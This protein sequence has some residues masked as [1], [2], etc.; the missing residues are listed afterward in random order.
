MNEPY[1]PSA[2]PMFNRR[3]AL[4]RRPNVIEALAINQSFET[5]AFRKSVNQTFAMLEG[6]SRQIAG[7]AGIQ[8]TVAPIGHKIKPPAS[9]ERSKAR[10][11]W[12]GQARP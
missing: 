9:H 2:R 11:G 8:D 7:D 10:R 5:M 3:L 1:L 4:N 6:A 12:P